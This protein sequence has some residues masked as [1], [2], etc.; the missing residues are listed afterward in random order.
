M[1]TM[2]VHVFM[3]RYGY[4]CVRVEVT[5]LPWV[6]L[7]ISCL[8]S[9]SINQASWHGN[10]WS[11]PVSASHCTTVCWGHRQKL[12]HP[13]FV[14]F[15]DPNSSPQTFVTRALPT[16]MSP[17]P[18]FSSGKGVCC[19]LSYQKCVKTIRLPCC[20]DHLAGLEF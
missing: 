20:Y 15:G 2:C 12:P 13:V 8:V 4:H 9:H 1:C 18:V 6:L 11:S 3:Y 16:E 10:F 5:G 19:L 14:G 17:Q 7:L